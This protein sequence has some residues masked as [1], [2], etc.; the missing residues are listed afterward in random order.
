MSELWTRRQS[1]G[2]LQQGAVA[3]SAIAF[4]RSL[5]ASDNNEARRSSR[6]CVGGRSLGENCAWEP[7]FCH[8]CDS[9]RKTQDAYGCSKKRQSCSSD[10][11]KYRDLKELS[12]EDVQ[13]ALE[14]LV[15][16]G[17]FDDTEERNNDGNE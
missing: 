7:T 5:G 17:A 8:A 11:S 3:A 14:D 13:S 9:C 2:F 1:A 10:H 12:D 15:E 4:D 16:L 6:G